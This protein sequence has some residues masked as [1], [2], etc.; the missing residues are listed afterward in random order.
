MRNIS[1]LILSMAIAFLLSAAPTTTF[2]SSQWLE[3]AP[4]Y[5]PADGIKYWAETIKEELWLLFSFSQDQK[6]HRYLEQAEERIAEVE[7]MATRKQFKQINSTLMKYQRQIEKAKLIADKISQ[8]SAPTNGFDEKLAG[9]LLRQEAVLNEV[10]QRQEMPASQKETIKFTM[11]VALN[12]Y[13]EVNSRILEPT[14][15]QVTKDVEQKIP[16]LSQQLPAEFRLKVPGLE[17]N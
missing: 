12:T 2:A 6:A 7:A 17:G 11:D 16:N 5:T 9:G 3:K 10:S 4:G 14:K 13:D 15:S 1:K 8:T